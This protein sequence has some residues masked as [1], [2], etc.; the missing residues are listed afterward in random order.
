[1]TG[2]EHPGWFASLLMVALILIWATRLDRDDGGYTDSFRTV[3]K[4]Y[5]AAAAFALTLGGVFAFGLAPHVA[6]WLVLL[7]GVGFEGVQALHRDY[8]LRRPGAKIGY[9]S[10][11]DIVADLA[12]IVLAALLL[13]VVT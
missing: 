11:R 6:G 4:L 8:V 2:D 13:D 9:F 1:M 10:L 7:A 12:G 5:H 3:D